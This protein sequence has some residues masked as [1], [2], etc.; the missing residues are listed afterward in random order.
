MFVSH[1]ILNQNTMASGLVQ[2][3]YAS[4]VTDILD[5][6]KR[7]NLGKE[8][9]PCPVIFTMGYPRMPMTRDQYEGLE[10]FREACADLAKKTSE[11]ILSFGEMGFKIL[12][13][14]GIAGSPS[15]GIHQTKIGR[16]SDRGHRTERSSIF[17]E[18]L[19]RAMR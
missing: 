19:E 15:R 5:L 8:Q 9:L 3:G 1:L 10:G 2:R 14:V 4:T 16:G 11:Y 6:F 7:Y 18:E 17:M 12:G 13:I